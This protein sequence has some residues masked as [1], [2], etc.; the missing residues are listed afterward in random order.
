MPSRYSSNVTFYRG[1]FVG[2]HFTLETRAA[3]WS[4]KIHPPHFDKESFLTPF[5]NL[6]SEAQWQFLQTAQISL[7]KMAQSGAPAVLFILRHL[8]LYTFHSQA[9]WQE[10]T[11]WQKH[12][13]SNN[14]S[15]IWEP[16]H[17][18][19]PLNPTLKSLILNPITIILQET[20]FLCIVW[21]YLQGNKY[22]T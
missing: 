2:K 8:Y 17:H 14:W 12:A 11:F 15:F 18:W 20:S 21:E 13:G 1:K 9:I 3:T 19:F 6:C 5:V 16:S 4:K 10:C 7:T 22:L